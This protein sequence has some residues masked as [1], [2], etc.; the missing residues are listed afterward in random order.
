MPEE[1]PAQSSEDKQDPAAESED[2]ED[3]S[4]ESLPEENVEEE[5][6]ADDDDDYYTDSEYSEDDAVIEETYE[7]EEDDKSPEA[8]L[9]RLNEVIESRDYKKKLEREDRD[10]V[11]YED[12]FNF[13][14]DPEKWR[15]EDLDEYWEDAPLGMTE[16]GWDPVWADEEDWEV[17]REELEAGNDP[18]IAPFYVPYRRFCPVIPD[19][20]F[21][22]SSPKAVIEEL[23]RIEEFLKWV[24]YIFPDGSSYE[25]TVWDDLAHGKGVYIAENGLVRYEGEWLQ[26]NMEGHGVVEVDIPGRE[27][28]PGSK[29]EAKMRSEG[30]IVARDYM[31]PE[32]RKWLE[33][34]IA[35]SVMLANGRYEIPWDDNDEWVRQFG[36]KPE[37]GRYRYAGQWK[38]SRMHGCGVYEVNER[39]IFGRFYFGELMQ[40]STGCDADVATLHAG[41]AEVAAAK[42]RMFVNKPDGMVREER[43]PFNDPQHPYFYDEDDV[44]M[45]PGFIN[46][47]F[48][49]PDYWKRYAKDVDQEREMWLNSFYKAPL[50]IPM[51]AELSYW[52]EKDQNPEF[53]LI[54]QEPEP[55][56]DDP[57]KL[58][59]TEDPLIVHTPTGR[60]INYVDDEEHGIR[61]FWQPPL[62]EGEEV[63]PSKAQFLPLGYDEFFGRAVPGQK[64]E[65]K[66][67][68]LVVAVENFLKP[69][70]EKLDKWAEEMKKSSDLKLKLID[71]ELEFVEAQICL[72][73]TIDDYENALKQQQKE[74]EKSGE[75]TRVE[76]ED[77]SS[78]KVESESDEEDG[79][80]QDE[81]SPANFGSVFEVEATK[82]IAKDDR[83]DKGTK[84]RG[85]PFSASSLS[86]ASASLASAITF[87]LHE[88]LRGWKKR[89][90]QSNTTELLTG[91]QELSNSSSPMNANLVTFPQL[92]APYLSLKALQDHPKFLKKT[93]KNSQ[94]QMLAKVIS[95]PQASSRS[96]TSL[97]T[98][99]LSNLNPK[100]A[101]E[102]EEDLR[103][104][105]SLH[106]PLHNSTQCPDIL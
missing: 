66:L 101:S 17:V 63:D 9:R 97:P 98:K 56:P 82:D 76:N 33:M 31:S 72:E 77:I 103:W 16:P 73:E 64:K 51:P 68:R 105:L 44:W 35:D 13:P 71:Q 15:E 43:G 99:E 100:L 20:H 59:Y 104:I 50:R 22:I 18:K 69:I 88:S 94:L 24:S 92:Y 6:G 102:P 45:A 93:N 75:M 25:G 58:I 34:D 52:W 60:I 85:S 90:R 96:K 106:T 65:G 42:A 11:F 38:H 41:I 55:D 1:N 37:K 21:D 36:S 28:I 47:F 54:N 91:S 26:N 74:E 78:D 80:E 87:N 10:Y 86:F 12:N 2:E 19:N 70:F 8:M 57:S 4:S 67:M 30:R 39:I 79:E 62:E 14:E 81:E 3:S 27:P 32:D 95:G 61:L 49:V 29:L 46:Q 48:E 23:D 7:E 53:V 89:R 83:K 5:A 40:D 84:P